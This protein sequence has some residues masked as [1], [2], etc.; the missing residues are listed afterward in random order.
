MGHRRAIQDEQLEELLSRRRAGQKLRDIQLWLKDIGQPAS[1][2]TI[3]NVLAELGE[4]SQTAAADRA[5]AVA[6]PIEDETPPAERM[7]Q[8]RHAVAKERAAAKLNVEEDWKRY[9]SALKMT[10]ELIKV[11][12]RPAAVAQAGAPAAAPAPEPVVFEVD[13]KPFDLSGGNRPQA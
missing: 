2:G 3:H 9:H 5:D 10:F 1:I 13:G 4:L 6:V 7:K 11:E 8:L 12:L